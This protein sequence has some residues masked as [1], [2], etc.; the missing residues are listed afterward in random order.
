M[1]ISVGSLFQNGQ[2][3]QKKATVTVKGL[4]HMMP[5]RAKLLHHGKRR[6]KGDFTVFYSYLKGSCKAGRS[7]LFLVVAK[8]ITT[9]HRLWLT[10]V[11]LD[12]KKKHF[13]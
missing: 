1:V 13:H 9:D 4:K 10:E 5:V 2:K 3:V 6:L 7:K 11:K 8:N 12:I